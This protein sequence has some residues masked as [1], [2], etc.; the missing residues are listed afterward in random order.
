MGKLH[1][2]T[3]RPFSLLFNIRSN[4]GVIHQLPIQKKA[5]VGESNQ[6][7][8]DRKIEREFRLKPGENRDKKIK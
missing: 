5:Y 8:Q 4:S 2:Q 7:G 6:G 3:K 1:W